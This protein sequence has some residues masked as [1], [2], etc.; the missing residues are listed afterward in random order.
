MKNTIN[1]LLVRVLGIIALTAIIGFSMTACGGGDAT[2]L[3]IIPLPDGNKTL[4]SINV[5][6]P[7]TKTDYNIGDTLDTTGMVVTATY[8]DESTAAVTGYTTSGFSS[9]TAGQKTVTVTYEGKTANF[10]VTVHPA[11]T[12]LTGIAV[13][14]PPT[15]TDYNLGEELDTAGMVV[16]ATYS[17]GST[18]AVT[19]YTTSGYDKNTKGNHKVTVTYQ[20][21]TAEFEVN[22][23]DPT[24]QTVAKPVASPAA[25]TYTAMQNVTLTTTTSGA[26]IY[27]TTNGTE[28][29]KTSTL[30]SSAISISATTTLKAI[31]VKD[32]MN[33]SDILTAVYTITVNKV[34]T[35]I[36]VTTPPTKTDYNLGE[37]LN[38]AGM[39]VTATYSDGSSQ[40]VTGYTTSGYDKNT[41]GNHKVT[42]TYQGKTAEFEVNV[43]DPTL[44]TVAKP[45]A[46]P[47]A[48][49]YAA[50]QNVTLT[51][52]TSGAAIYYTT[53]GTEPTKTSTLYS[54]AISIS[55]TT[56]LKAIAVKEGMNDSDMLTAVYTI[57]TLVSIA[58]TTPPTK[59]VY[60]LNET[61]NTAGMVVTATYSDGS[62]AAVT[63]YTLSGFSSTT[64]GQKTVT[65]TYEGKTA[66]FTV[67]VNNPSFTSIADFATWLSS[68]PTNNAATAYTVKLNV[69]SLGGSSDTTDSAGKALKDNYSKYVNIDL[70]GSTMTSIENN[71]FSQCS[72]L[73]SVT[74]PNTVTSIGDGAFSCYN[75]TSVTIPNT[76]TSIG[77]R[78]FESCANLTGITIP[79]SVTSIG[80]QAFNGCTSLTDI[81]IPTSV[82]NIGTGAFSGCTKLTAINVDNA[83][84]AYSS[85]DGVLYNKDKT[86]LIKYPNVKTGAFT[87]PA[88]VTNIG[89]AFYGCTGL[90]SVTIPASVTSIGDGAFS[91]CTGLTSVTIGNGVTS[92]GE[93]AFQNC[94]SL[95][96]ITIPD[97]VT[98]IRYDAFRG[99]TGLTSITIPNTVTSIQARTFYGCTGLTDVTI[100]NGV[101]SIEGQ[102][103]Y[104]CTGLT[105][106]IIPNTVTI[107][108]TAFQNCTSLTSI[109]IPFV[110]ATSNGTSNTHFGFIFGASS[111]SNQYSS[112]PASL[113]TVIIT[114]GTSIRDDAFRNCTSLTS[115]TIPT[116][117]TSIGSQAFNGCTSLTDIT[118]PTSVTNIGTGAFLGCTKLTAINVDNA[119]NAYSSQD[120][121][122]YNKDKT[123]LIKYPNG[124]TGAFTIP[125]SVTTIQ[126]AA[127][128]SCT[129]LTSVTIPNSVTSI[130]YGAFQ[131][132]TN[133]TSVMFATGSN[134]PDANFASYAFPEGNY[135][136]GGETLKT[137]YSTG[138]AGTYTRDAN[139]S[140]WTKQP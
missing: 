44:Q 10:T 40:A 3:P 107:I 19:G 31:A 26:A 70:S 72:S 33:D 104:G 61:L 59:T 8:S 130:E 123:T 73:T 126:S 46:S 127:F 36:A 134:I 29:T 43:I 50:A 37:E 56:T 86:T 87:I 23:I 16:T 38:T 39:V 63:G 100:G 41:K 131:N 83:N 35:G 2:P 60:N 11:G 99:C 90:T 132:C 51:T 4:V 28:P 42:V 115:V 91:G 17:D 93:S 110:G 101:T 7:P 85:Q 21:K 113:K 135:G 119:N 45:V 138:K 53:N 48:G 65:V 122:L 82:T 62:T 112:I 52:A 92:I 55:A 98:S 84:N 71:A 54:S 118:I 137:A 125:A 94:T 111:Y 117:V 120:G 79:N 140:T 5:T 97:N 64:A 34:L 129:S 114:G 1:V 106:I 58:V 13:T 109:T 108:D 128:N 20:G 27:Y 133:L 9:T 76:V 22:V 139:G 18:Q 95:T 81:T 24:L 49:T 77:S 69:N 6:T 15:K 74:I 124:K 96:G 102:A 12:T 78:A 136:N 30:Y 57:R 105:S 66:T 75:L 116:S 80:S 67:T 25:G 32:G 89:S 88:S 14:T 68:Q 47:A 103:F 121:V